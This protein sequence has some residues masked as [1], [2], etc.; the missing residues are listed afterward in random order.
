M[1]ELTDQGSTDDELEQLGDD[2]ATWDDFD[3]DSDGSQHDVANRE[4]Q[5]GDCVTPRTVP[6]PT[7]GGRPLRSVMTLSAAVSGSSTAPLPVA[8]DTG[9]TVSTV[10]NKNRVALLPA[11]AQ[12]DGSLRRTWQEAGEA[13]GDAARRLDGLPLL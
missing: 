4:K 10:A 12:T 9:R 13:S 8:A 6:G 11:A 2:D 1:D 3:H 7:V 5:R